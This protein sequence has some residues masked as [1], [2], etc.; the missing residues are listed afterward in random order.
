M[1]KQS[2]KYAIPALLYAAHNNMVQ[3]ASVTL[4]LSLLHLSFLILFHL[5]PLNTLPSPPHRLALP[6]HNDH[7]VRDLVVRNSTGKLNKLYLLLY[8]CLYLCPCLSPPVILAIGSR[9]SCCEST[10]CCQYSH[11]YPL[12]PAGPLRLPLSP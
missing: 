9:K 5:P 3:R 7:H 1:S 2:L 6:C 10:A 11:I 12:P 4:T 8:L